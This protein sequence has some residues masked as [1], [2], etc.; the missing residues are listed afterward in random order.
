M[1]PRRATVVKVDDPV[2][3]II[4]PTMAVRLAGVN[5]PERGTR[6]AEEARRKLGR[7]IARVA[8]DGLD[9]NEEMKAFIGGLHRA[10]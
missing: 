10:L 8:V 2:T 3:F 7:S 4:R 5:P 6:E 1:S 9:V